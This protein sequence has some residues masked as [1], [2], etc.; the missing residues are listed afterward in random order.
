[1]QSI[2]GQDKK[3][4]YW[5]FGIGLALHLIAAWYSLGFF[6]YDEHYQILEFAGLKAGY[7]TEKD[8]PWEYAARIR[9]TL[10]PWIAYGAIE[11]YKSITG[12]FDPFDIATLLR[13]V[14]G[15]LGW[16]SLVVFTLGCLPWLRTI[17]TRRIAFVA[18]AFF[19]ILTFMHVRF[20]SES[21][22]SSLFFLALGW[23]LIQLHKYPDDGRRIS[24]L[25][26]A[27][28]GVLMGLSIVCRIQV[29]TLLPG[30]FLY[31]LVMLR[32]P[33]GRLC[34]MGFGVLFALL[35]GAWLDR[36][37]YG[38]WVNTAW[39]YFDVNIRQGKAATFGTSPWYDYFPQMVDYA[40]GLFAV[41]ITA[42]VLI[43]LIRFPKNILTW[44]LLPFLII[45]LFIGHK[46]LRFLFPLLPA[47]PVMAAMVYQANLSTLRYKRLHR[48]TAIIAVAA[49]GGYNLVKLA[50]T[51]TTPY[52]GEMQSI[53]YISD[54]YGRTPYKI[55]TNELYTLWFLRGLKMNFYI[56]RGTEIREYKSAKD[57][58]SYVRK[59]DRPV[60]IIW[61]SRG[62]DFSPEY[63]SLGEY[64][65]PAHYD[66]Q[67]WLKKVN[68][69]D[70]IKRTTFFRVYH[71]NPGS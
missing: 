70:W 51:C 23:L 42:I 17:T 43:F 12:K 8:L 34:V 9:P 30:L 65:E 13:F 32:V 28:I 18:G 3:W 47:L 41:T 15:L 24:W 21:W 59:S 55:V 14:S 66:L 52:F 68:Y 6:H 46:E 69:N 58:I 35:F 63:K 11:L 25:P 44:T 33:F 16:F 50:Q 67:E 54:T 7:T 38:E 4:L 39:L 64:C 20:S 19:W 56:P 57:I 26:L 5:C 36:L 1:M 40:G 48:I 62:F 60:L 10:Q 27:A 49:L 45:H 71:C 61:R 37:F 22:S 2:S 53:K 29:G 31:L